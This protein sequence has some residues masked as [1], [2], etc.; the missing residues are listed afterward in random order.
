MGKC[1]H[2]GPGKFSL[3]PQRLDF[4]FVKGGDQNNRRI[5]GSQIFVQLFRRIKLR[6][7]TGIIIQKIP[8]GLGKTFTMG[9]RQIITCPA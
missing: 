5:F 4:L 1:G 3:G 9:H 6:Q 2:G 8:A 7:E